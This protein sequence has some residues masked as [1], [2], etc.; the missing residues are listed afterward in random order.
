M[1][2]SFPQFAAVSGSIDDTFVGCRYSEGVADDL[3]KAIWSGIAADP[4][5]SAAGVVAQYAQYHFHTAAAPTMQ[6]ALLGLEQNWV[7]DI[8]TNRHIE[9]TLLSLQ[10]AERLTPPDELLTNWRLQMYLY[11]GYCK[12]TTSNHSWINQA[13]ECSLKDCL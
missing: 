13:P 10:A 12:Y 2:Y 7:G 9:S 11:R 5:Q 8:S 4:R 3:N 6:S 1:H